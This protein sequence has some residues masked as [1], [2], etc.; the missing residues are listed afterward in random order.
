[1]KNRFSGR[2]EIAAAIWA[3]RRPFYVA[4]GFSFVIN[5]LMLMPTIYMLQ[6]YDRV[7]GSRNEVTLYMITLITLALYLLL[8]GLE[9]VRSRVLVHVGANFDKA[10]N[11][12]V[13]NAAFETN[14]N[15][16]GSNAGQAL[17]DLTNVRQFITGNGIFAFFDA[18]WFPIYLAVIFVLHPVLG[19]FSIA[20]AIIAI[21]LTLINE[22]ATRGPLAQANQ[23]AIVS[24]AFATNNLKNA[25]VIQAM[26]MLDNLRARWYKR[27]QDLLALQTIA[28]GRAGMIS[29]CSKFFRIA[30]QSLI[31]GL[32]AYLVIKGEMSASGMIAGSILM[33]RALAPVDLLI[34]SWRGLI[35]ARV[36]FTRL[37]EMLNK[38]PVSAETMQLPAPK[39]N[40]SVE[41]VVAMAPGGKTPI[42]KGVSFAL[43]QGEAMALIGPSASGKSTL[44]RLL[45]GVWPAMNG[46]VRLDGADV[47]AWNKL[48]LGPHIG[49]LPQDVELFDGTIA[50]NIARFGE[51]DHE[52]VIDAAQM[53]GVH[54]MILR[55]PQ[56]YDTPIGVG[57]SFLSGGQRQRIALARAVYGHPSL[58]VLDEPNA[59]LDDQG[60]QALVKAVA[61]LKKAGCTVILITHR[62]SIISSVDKILM[63]KEGLVAA[64]GPRDDVLKSMMEGAARAR[65][66]AANTGVMAAVPAA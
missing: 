44:A 22:L 35:S 51:I 52:K 38:Y 11:S 8:A 50:E 23:A 13:F 61:A 24:N 63:M 27:Y 12:R 39:G 43:A 42:L 15:S 66:S 33:G 60:E 3:L 14:L 30:Q 32:G 26:G 49:Y 57:G 17:A 21:S 25:E 1:M 55:F 65:A 5:M 53:T 16:A 7:L 56:G 37:E 59:S 28:S 18:P 41:A 46:K 64:F 29:A 54:E 48:E 2:S 34:S 10:L 40:L 31:L 4:G 19:W 36:A 58:V 62:T 45:V 20:G 6:M 9:W 47:Y